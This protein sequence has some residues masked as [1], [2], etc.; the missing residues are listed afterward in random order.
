[1]ALSE[2]DRD[3]LHELLSALS[4][5][6]VDDAGADRLR[7]LLAD[8]DAQQYYVNFAMLD[9][10]LD[11]ASV[12]AEEPLLQPPCVS[13]SRCV[14]PLRKADCRDPRQ[15]PRSP[16]L[17]FLR[18][19]T[20]A[21]SGTPFGAALLS[22]F[23]VCL[24]GVVVALLAVIHGHGAAA[25]RRPTAGT[26]SLPAPAIRLSPAPALPA[27]PRLSPVAVARLMNVADCQWVVAAAAPKPGDRFC[28]GQSLQLAAGAACIEFDVGAKL[29]LQGPAELSIV[30]AK[31]IRLDR[32]KLAAEITAEKARGFT[33]VT[34]QGSVVDLGTE[35]GV[36]VAPQGRG[37]VHVFRGKV[38][39]TPHS[40][41]GRPPLTTQCLLAHSGARM[42]AGGDEITLVEDTGEAF[43]RS[44]DRL[45]KDRHVVAYWR[46]E[47]RPLGTA[48]PHT[49]RN[50]EAMIATVDSSFNGND[51]YA[52]SPESRPKFSGD[53]PQDEVPQ[54]HSPNRGCLD[55]SEPPVDRS[56]PLTRNVYT[57]SAFSHAAPIDI[58]KFSPAQWT[59]EASA[60]LSRLDVHPQTI[61][62]RDTRFP[63]SIRQKT[64]PQRLS[65]EITQQGRFAIRFYDVDNRLHEAVAAELPVEI[66][67]WY[68]LAAVSDGRTLKLYVN[69]QDDRGYRLGATTVLPT[70]GNT[71]LGKGEDRAEWTI[72]RGLENGLLGAGFRGLIDEVRVSDIARQP[73]ELL[74]APGG[75]PARSTALAEADR[76]NGE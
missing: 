10:C 75:P 8:P 68:H 70:T 58:Q 53:V 15:A 67:R 65:L 28:A 52:W 59:I 47:D 14:S 73:G 29:V 35:F 51:L 62:G 39:F 21:G 27:A 26:P 57:H 37:K 42:E 7:E 13:A 44:L 17:G 61:I 43:V 50:T 45:E 76:A 9:A 20:R 18:G 60:R 71:A 33:V 54:T 12:E 34:P 72:G 38:E 25:D 36:E 5:G 11:M 4:D 24:I 30:S 55:S 56:F 64:A 66:N 16:V 2:P 40:A 23:A 49:V 19:V 1:M 48:P 32:G 6:R 63:P 74:F 31:Q 22:V 3:R 41:D 69:S 46:F